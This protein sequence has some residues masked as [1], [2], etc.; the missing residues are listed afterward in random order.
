M[1]IPSNGRTYRPWKTS[2]FGVIVFAFCLLPMLVL[3]PSDGRAEDARVEKLMA[4]LTAQTT[5]LGAPKLEG[6]EAVGGKDAPALCFGSTKMNNNVAVV[7][8][9]AKEGGH[10][11]AATLFVKDGDKF[12]RVA[13][14]LAKPN[15]TGRAIGTVLDTGPALD[16]LKSGKAYNGEVTLSKTT[17]VAS[18]EPITDASGAVIGAY[19]VGV[20]K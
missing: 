12:V 14:T 11:V 19:F 16:A 15:K 2:I 20:K 17:Y 3:T 7:D 8:A 18:Y 6:K 5:K 4:S 9:V 1:R 10:G 13:T